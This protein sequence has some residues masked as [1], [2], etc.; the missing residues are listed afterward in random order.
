ME[1]LSTRNPSAAGPKGQPTTVILDSS[2]ITS[3][4]LAHLPS[5]LCLVA[6]SL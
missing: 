5:P 4:S 1:T 6:N 2:E 3:D